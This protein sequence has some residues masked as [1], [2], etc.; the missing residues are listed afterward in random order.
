M[1]LPVSV[2]DADVM[3]RSS[4][5]HQ[6][7]KI[8]TINSSIFLFVFLRR[9]YSKAIRNQ[10]SKIHALENRWSSWLSQ[11][12]DMPI[13]AQE[14]DL[15]RSQG[16]RGEQRS[17]SVIT[18]DS[19]FSIHLLWGLAARSEDLLRPNSSS[20][21][22]LTVSQCCALVLNANQKKQMF[23]LPVSSHHHQMA[24]G[25]KRNLSLGWMHFSFWS[26]LTIEMCY[27]FYILRL[28]FSV[29]IWIPT[30]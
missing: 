28:F 6:W 16:V 21:L 27:I 10:W 1:A 2:E 12:K 8:F 25:K 18:L 26:V 30:V 29:Y 19:Y 11:Q 15:T 7:I 5:L 9:H 20:W 22:F 24:V 4:D 14:Q 3:K 23:L 17:T 13:A